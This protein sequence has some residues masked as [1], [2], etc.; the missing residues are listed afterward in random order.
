MEVCHVIFLLLLKSTNSKFYHKKINFVSFEACD[1]VYE[2]ST[3]QF[4]SGRTLKLKSNNY[5]KYKFH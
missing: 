1:I 3:A 2:M 4:K 5:L